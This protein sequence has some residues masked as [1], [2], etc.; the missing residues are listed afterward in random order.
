M[1]VLANVVNA[2][3]A[4]DRA[5]AKPAGKAPS[6]ESVLASTLKDLM[7]AK[8]LVRKLP[9]TTTRDKLELLLTRTE[10]QLKQM[11]G[12]MN[13]PKPTPMSS[14]DFNRFSV[15]LRN[16]SFDKDKVT[17]LENFMPGRY[18]SCLQASILLKH[19]SFDNDRIKAAIYLHGFVTDVENFNRVL[20]VFTFDASKK[21]VMEQLKRK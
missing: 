1:L 17:F 18:V 6:S 11:S 12:N 10:L 21:T 8:E 2:Q 19:F 13:G 20:E 14:D 5:S 3:F 15:N 9:P 4:E 7:E 16:Q